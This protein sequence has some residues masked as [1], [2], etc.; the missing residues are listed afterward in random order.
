MALPPPHRGPRRAAERGR[1]PHGGPADPAL[2]AHMSRGPEGGGESTPEVPV[3]FLLG[4][5]GGGERGAT[6]LGLSAL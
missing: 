2:G 5:G 1:R 3:P 6:M 4:E